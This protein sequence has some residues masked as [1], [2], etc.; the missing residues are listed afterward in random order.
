MKLLRIGCLASHNGTNV[1]AIID[2]CS[3]Q[4]LSAE[5]VVVISNNSESQVLSRASS[6]KIPGIHLSST[7]HPNPDDLDNAINRTLK[8]Y[9]VELVVLAGYMKLIGPKVLANYKPRIVNIHPSLLPKYGGEFMYGKRVHEAILKAR[10]KVTGVTIHLV[11]TEYDRGQIITQSKVE[12]LKNDTVDSLSARVHKRE[13]RVL[14]DTIDRI[15]S[16]KIDLESV[17]DGKKNLHLI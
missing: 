15:I 11:D 10:E 9:S 7:T 4:R 5:V 17:A 6:S 3:S 16:G 8:E 1:Q 13:H 14:V 12:V 2:A